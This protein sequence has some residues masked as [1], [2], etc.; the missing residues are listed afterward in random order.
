MAESNF[1]GSA[2]YTGILNVNGDGGWELFVRK[3][4]GSGYYSSAAQAWSVS[5]NGSYFSGSWTYDFRGTSLIRLASNAS[6]GAY[7][8]PAISQNVGASWSINM[9]SGLGNSS[10]SFA[11]WANG[12][13]GVPNQVPWVNATGVTSSSFTVNWGAPADN[14]AALNDYDLHICRVAAHDPNGAAYY[15]W[16]GSTA[17]SRAFTGQPRGTVFYAAVRAQNGVGQGA[18]SNWYQFQL[19]HTVPDKPAAPTLVSKTS[20]SITLN[21]TEAPYVGAGAT[22]REVSYSTRSDFSANVTTISPGWTFTIDS[23]VKNTTYYAR[24]RVQDAVGWGAWS[25]AIAV[26][27]PVDQPT[28]PSGYT[29][30]DITSTTAYS[31]LPYV[32]DN[33]GSSLV[34]LRIERNTSA[35]SS[36]STVTT[37]GE[38]VAAFMSG[39]PVGTQYY[40]RMAVKNSGEGAQWSDYGP[41]VS[42]TTKSN[43]PGPPGAPTIS[44]V[45]DNQATATW[46]APGS[47]NGST[48]TGYTIR[49]SSLPS[50]SSSSTWTVGAAVLTKLLDGLQPGTKYYVQVWSNSNNGLGSYSTVPTFTTTGVAPSASSVWTRVGG[51]W[52]QGT[53][54]L[55]V[56]GVWKAV[57]PWVRIGG[58][59]RKL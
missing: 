50:F 48:I 31:G 59:W 58:V 42:F 56:G 14:G 4:S 5:I 46:T 34:D 12:T 8:R 38:Y 39:L 49:V 18:W 40:Y 24:H 52:R 53:L 16:T 47:L 29:P 26:T 10:G 3:N 45:S 51:V 19:A 41:W 57:V 6:H 13:A 55:R 11:F 25:D 22:A 7:A 1:S 17:T 27:T 28:A 32:A 33:G 21:L 30:T 20:T 37:V 35:S 54:Y 9:A 43:V 36:G 15:N 23:L 2:A 44:A